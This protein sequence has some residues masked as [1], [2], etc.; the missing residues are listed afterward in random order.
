M[1]E[2]PKLSRYE[3]YEVTVLVAVFGVGGFGAALLHRIPP[4][5]ERVLPTWGLY[6]LFVTMA[7]AALTTLTGIFLDTIAGLN[8]RRGGSIA[9]AGL[10]AAFAVWTLSA[11]GVAAYRSVIFLGMVT[12][13]ALWQAL[14]VHRA[15]RPRRNS[16]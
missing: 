6:V 8:L 12:I 3:P 13:A 10:C 1:T 11:A 5:A 9:M 15:L 7:L 4:S 16:R 14:R 2:P